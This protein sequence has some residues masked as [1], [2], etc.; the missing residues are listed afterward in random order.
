MRAY[1]GY[2]KNIKVAVGGVAG[3][4]LGHVCRSFGLEEAPGKVGR[5][6]ESVGSGG[7]GGKRED[8]AADAGKTA[9]NR[10]EK[11]KEKGKEERMD[12]KAESVV[13]TLALFKKRRI[14]TLSEFAA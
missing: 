14:D 3:L 13:D 6:R 12:R 5:M 7:H 8:G 9:K 10:K 4:H 1:A 11:V 2:P